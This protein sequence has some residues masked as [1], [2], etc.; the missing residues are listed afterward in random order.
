MK[1]TLTHYTIIVLFVTTGIASFG[2]YHYSTEYEKQK[3]ANGL[4]A[5][6][7]RQLTDTL[8][9][10]NTHI[11]MLHEMDTKHTQ[12]LANDKA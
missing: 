7:I 6:E 2:S 3:E 11:D 1:L 10:Q 8:N 9:Y 12:E 5:T 4:Q